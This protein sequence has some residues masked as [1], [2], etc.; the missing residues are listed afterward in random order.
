M[1]AFFLKTSDGILATKLAAASADIWRT[2]KQP[3]TVLSIF[4]FFN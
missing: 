2:E 1:T 4:R 3:K